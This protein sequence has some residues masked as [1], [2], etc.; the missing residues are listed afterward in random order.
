LDADEQ[1]I[2]SF[3]VINGKLKLLPIAAARVIFWFS[4]SRPQSSAGKEA[5]ASPRYAARRRRCA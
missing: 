2:N 4:A 3:Q 5:A 1:S